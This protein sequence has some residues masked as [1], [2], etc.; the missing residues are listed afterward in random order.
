VA[1]ASVTAAHRFAASRVQL[2]K[3]AD[4]SPAGTTDRANTKPE[5]ERSPSTRP[6]RSTA[7]TASRSIG[8]IAPTARCFRTT[9]RSRSRDR[10]R[11]AGILSNLITLRD[12]LID[13]FRIFV[14]NLSVKHTHL[15]D[16]PMDP[17][18]NGEVRRPRFGD[19]R[20]RQS[21]AAISS[22]NEA[23]FHIL[24]EYVIDTPLNEVLLPLL[25]N[26]FFWRSS[27]RGFVAAEGSW[28]TGRCRYR[29]LHYRRAAVVTC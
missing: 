17:R 19:L 25:R 18:G 15:G 14:N 16:K 28:R 6:K 20:F 2:L 22:L 21:V 13:L 23:W 29:R 9:S 10:G 11:G 4:S 7:N 8:S 5:R 12:F 27:L 1:L 24:D 26:C 3:R